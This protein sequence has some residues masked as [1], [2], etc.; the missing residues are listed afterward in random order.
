[1]SI[2]YNKRNTYMKIRDWKRVTARSLLLL[3]LLQYLGASVQTV[4]AAQKKELRRARA[5]IKKEYQNKKIAGI[6]IG[7]IIKGF[8]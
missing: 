2:A 6:D 8:N 7:R 1:M 5:N 3:V 4:N